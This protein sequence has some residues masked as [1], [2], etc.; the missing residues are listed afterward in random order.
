MNESVGTID[1]Y[2][3]KA[4]DLV[5][6]RETAEHA[7]AWKAHS[8]HA[9]PTKAV[10]CTAIQLLLLMLLLLLLLLLLDLLL[11]LLLL[12]LLSLMLG[13]LLGKRTSGIGANLAGHGCSRRADGG[14]IERAREAGR[15]RAVRETLR[16]GC[17]RAIAIICKYI[18]GSGGYES[19]SGR[20]TK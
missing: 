12:L 11:L 6:V 9:I 8:E 3:G 2:P 5:A 15:R 1:T 14:R 10:A 13:L 19:V 17:L 20:C 4:G 7:D 16:D 18:T